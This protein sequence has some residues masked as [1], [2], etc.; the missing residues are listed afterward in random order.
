MAEEKKT[1][2]E[3]DVLKRTLYSLTFEEL[4][5]YFHQVRCHLVR[6]EITNNNTGIKSLKQY[7]YYAIVEFAKGIFEVRVPLRMEEYNL[8]YISRNKGATTI[9]NSFSTSILYLAVNSTRTNENTGNT[10]NSI[11][12][13]LVFSDGIRKKIWLDQVQVE[14][15]NVFKPMELL[16]RPEL[17]E[18]DAEEM[19]QSFGF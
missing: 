18:D 10:W 13:K 8:L 2:T 19:Q 12:L 14:A 9:G 5:K 3:L 7:S 6:R 11:Q 1:N 4:Q 15:V 17:A 16:D